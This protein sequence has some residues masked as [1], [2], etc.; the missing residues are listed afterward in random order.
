[1]AHRRE[2]NGKHELIRQFGGARGAQ[3]SMVLL[4]CSQLLQLVGATC[5][6]AEPLAH[7]RALAK[8]DAH[9]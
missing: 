4:G 7:G 2:V 1:M 8:L 5:S 9:K 3:L 6:P